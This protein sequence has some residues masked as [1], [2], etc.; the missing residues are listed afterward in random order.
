MRRVSLSLAALFAALASPALANGDPPPRLGLGLDLSNADGALLGLTFADS[1]AALSSD[2]LSVGWTASLIT[3]LR[4]H[5]VPQAGDLVP[6]YIGDPTLRLGLI[7]TTTPYD[8]PYF[9]L[10][11]GA[12][13]ESKLS[14]LDPQ[15]YIFLH[16]QE[17]FSYLKI[18]FETRYRVGDRDF[19]LDNELTFAGICG[20]QF[21]QAAPAGPTYPTD[22]EFGEVSGTITSGAVPEPATWAVMVLGFGAA[23]ASLR[24]RRAASVRFPGRRGS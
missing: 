8:N 18:R 1:L 9:S 12:V 20:F 10:G 6:G 5:D 16:V 24:R 2:G 17:E 15:P 19:D 4:L 11:G 23:G 3:P 14:D 21:R 7:G 13:L 22:C